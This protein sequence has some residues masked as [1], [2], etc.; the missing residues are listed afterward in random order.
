MLA[1]SK[2]LAIVL[3][4]RNVLLKRHGLKQRDTRQS[5]GLHHLMLFG[6]CIHPDMCLTLV[7]A[8][9]C[10]HMVIADMCFPYE[11]TTMA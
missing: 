2:L 9:S 11:S 3:F 4:T 5:K 6:P 7:R 1:R 10:E 8:I